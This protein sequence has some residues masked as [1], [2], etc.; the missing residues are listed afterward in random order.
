MREPN[1]R[2]VILPRL[3]NF[4][5]ENEL[6]DLKRYHIWTDALHARELA[7][8]TQG[9]WDRGAYVRWSV[10]SAWT[11]FEA[12]AGAALNYSLGGN[13]KSKLKNALAK[14]EIPLDWQLSPWADIG[15]L[16]DA[17]RNRFVHSAKEPLPPLELAEHA[18]ETVRKGIR[19]VYTLLDRAVPRWI[20]QDTAAGWQGRRGMFGTGY[21][22]VQGA[23]PTSPDTIVGGYID[24]KGVFCP[25]YY[26]K[27]DSDPVQI[28]EKVL[29][30]LNISSGATAVRVLRVASPG[31]P[32]YEEKLATRR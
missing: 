25:L 2:S 3:K 7:R 31:S 29:E 16:Y 27:P 19:E 11:T 14:H 1:S 4:L 15:E 26:E 21:L 8:T 18:V 6:K 28:A 22:T 13:F 5:R 17:A 32:L 20:D 12:V 24:G 30:A 23:D 9:F 10:T